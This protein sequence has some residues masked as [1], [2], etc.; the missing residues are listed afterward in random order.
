MRVVSLTLKDKVTGKQ[1]RGEIVG[2]GVD[3]KGDAKVVVCLEDGTFQPWLL[4][5]CVKADVYDKKVQDEAQKKIAD[6]KA[7]ALE[8]QKLAAQKKRAAEIEEQLKR[9]EQEAKK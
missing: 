7:K 4:R 1:L 8:A 6:E 3:F 5:T 9:E 2:S